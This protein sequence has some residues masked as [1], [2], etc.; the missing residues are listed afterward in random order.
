MVEFSSREHLQPS[1]LDRLT[2]NA[3]ENSRDPPDQ[4]MLSMAQLRASVLRDLAWLFATTRLEVLEELDGLQEVRRSVLNYGLPAFTGLTSG[5]NRIAQ[6]ENAI[7][8]AIRVF[9]PRILRDTLRVK[10]RGLQN[11]SADGALV[12]EIQGELWAQPV[13]LRI[14]LET[15][16]E[17]ESNTVSVVEARARG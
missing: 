9:E 4:S 13:P 7:A 16:I 17:P 2:D 5:G 3:P 15:A 10:L 1:L 6:L 14:L 12:F 11:D 8:E